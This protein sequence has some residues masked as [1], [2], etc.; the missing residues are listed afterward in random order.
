MCDVNPEYKEDVR[1]KYGKKVLYLRVVKALYGCIE[2]ALLWYKMYVSTLKD[3]EFVINPYNKC[4]ANKVIN[5]KQCTILWYVDNNKLSHVEE[6]VVTEIIEDIK[7]DYGN[8]VVSRGKEYKFLGMNIMFNEND[9]VQ[10]GMKDY[11]I[12]AGEL[13]DKD[14]SKNVAYPAT[15]SLS[16]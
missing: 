10:I 4:V 16:M 15:K 11:I 2:S 1:H 14:V 8:L 7:A 3:M 6:K 5:G 13:F 9:S 12:E